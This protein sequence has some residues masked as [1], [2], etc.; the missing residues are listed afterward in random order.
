VELCNDL[1]RLGSKYTRAR[2]M[3]F[4]YLSTHARPMAWAV[5]STLLGEKVQKNL[6]LLPNINAILQSVFHVCGF[7]QGRPRRG[8]GFGGTVWSSGGHAAA[9]SRPLPLQ[10]LGL[11][12][13]RQDVARNIC[14]AKSVQRCIKIGN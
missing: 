5:L 1:G 9:A 2:W 10:R 13:R 11:S 12:L 6:W 8:T 4:V 7:M 14:T 3:R